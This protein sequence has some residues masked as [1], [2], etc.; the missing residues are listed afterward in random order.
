ME[1]LIF[2]SGV[3]EFQINNNGVLR[4]NP[5]DPN[6][7]DRILKSGEK[8]KDVERK[9]LQKAK[10]LA[11]ADGEAVSGAVVLQLI[12]EADAEI[13]NILAYIFG[14]DNNFDEIFAGTSTMAVCSNGERAIT[15]FL[16]ALLPIIQSGAEKC[17][18]QQIGDAVQKAK[19]N[20]AQRRAAAKK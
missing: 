9:L 13:K 3:R 18:K 11:P 19:G 6:V 7:Y 17:A 10:E 8:I 1:K 20:R 12:T 14:A 16:N 5:S 15:N 4:F 2:D